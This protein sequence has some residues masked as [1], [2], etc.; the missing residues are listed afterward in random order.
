LVRSGA[1]I[2]YKVRNKDRFY[3]MDRKISQERVFPRFLGDLLLHFDLALEN[4]FIYKHNLALRVDT[5]ILID[6][7]YM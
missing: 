1:H 5:Y 6:K 3:H 2:Y 4:K 7:Y